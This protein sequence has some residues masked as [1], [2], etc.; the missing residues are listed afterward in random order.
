LRHL[1]TS[2]FLIRT[3]VKAAKNYDGLVPPAYIEQLAAVRYDARLKEL[4]KQGRFLSY[5]QIQAIKYAERLK[6]QK[7]VENG[8]DVQQPDI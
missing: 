2:R 1:T 7:Q 4:Q 8:L 5:G 3:I 6:A